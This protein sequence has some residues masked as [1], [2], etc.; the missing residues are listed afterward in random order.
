MKDGADISSIIS[1][2]NDN[3]SEGGSEIDDVSK[4]I[5]LSPFSNN[6]PIKITPIKNKEET[7]VQEIKSDESEYDPP[8]LN[9]E[10]KSEVKR[11]NDIL[12][13]QHLKVRLTLNLSQSQLTHAKNG[14]K[15]KQAEEVKSRL[16]NVRVWCIKKEEP[17]EDD[18]TDVKQS[19]LR[20]IFKDLKINKDD[21]KLMEEGGWLNDK[22][23]MFYVN[24]LQ[25]K[26][27]KNKEFTNRVQIF[28]TYIYPHYENFFKEDLNMNKYKKWMDKKKEELW[29]DICI[30]PIN[31]GNHVKSNEGEVKADHWYLWIKTYHFTQNGELVQAITIF[32]SAEDY[33]SEKERKELFDRMRFTGDPFRMNFV[34]A[35]VPQQLNNDDWG[36]WVLSFIESIVENPQ[37]A[38]KAAMNE[39]LTDVLDINKVT[40]GKLK[41]LYAKADTLDHSKKH[42]A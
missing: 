28:D 5:N 20:K 34:I 2:F 31:G 33:I 7:S 3:M 13:T 30:F 6:S 23:I 32:D 4:E 1:C 17:T 42:K 41:E 18:F 35:K 12:D 16:V 22:I 8:N 19:S 10:Y 11:L 9:I 26:H 40:R 21:Y 25:E 14:K 27:K 36:V 15:S 38:F 29:K 39:N 37:I 24:Y